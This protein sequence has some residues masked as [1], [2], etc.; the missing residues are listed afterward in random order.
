MHKIFLHRNASKFYQKANKSLKGKISVA[1]DAISRNPHLDV[2]VKKLK[3]ELKHMHRFRFGDLRILYEIDYAVKTV[4]IKTIE[5][6][7]TVYK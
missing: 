4:W 5:W 2:H 3:G 6:R 1:I 7:G